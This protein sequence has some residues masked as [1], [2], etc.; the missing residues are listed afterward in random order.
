MKSASA[1][2][3]LTC[4]LGWLSSCRHTKEVMSKKELVAFIANKDNGLLSEHQIND[5]DVRVQYQPSS[6]LVAQEI[7]GPDMRNNQR[8]IDSLEKKY[9]NSYYF[10]IKFSKNNKEAIRQLGSFD[11]YSDMVSVLSFELPRFINLTTPQKDTVELS[12]YLFDQT[13]GASDAN[14]VLLAFA[15]EKLQGKSVLHVNLSEC[16]FGTGNLK[17]SFKKEDIDNVPQMK[18][19]NNL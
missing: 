16:G 13:Y 7:A 3:L 10:L 11:R 2:L 12:D 8:L 4:C 6:L 18:Y 17:F 9:S 15:K 19:E 5:I 1:L 14:T